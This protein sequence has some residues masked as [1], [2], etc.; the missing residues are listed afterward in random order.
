[1]Y[2]LKDVINDKTIICKSNRKGR[3]KRY[4]ATCFA[5]KININ[6]TIVR[7]GWAIAYRKYSTDYIEDEF[8]AQQK[9]S[10]MWAGRFIPPSQWR[11]QNKKK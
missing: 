5:N 9:R 2:F 3:Y 1:M 11:V 6:A 4:I 7:S 10:G 8:Y